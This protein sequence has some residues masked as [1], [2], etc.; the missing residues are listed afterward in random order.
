[1][2]MA[3]ETFLTLT[4]KTL[5]KLLPLLGQLNKQT[6]VLEKHMKN[7]GRSSKILKQ[8]QK[9][10]SDET[11]K[12]AQAA[13]D[14][15]SALDKLNK[16][17]QQG[18]R[19]S[20]SFE[21]FLAEEVKLKS[22]LI[23]ANDKLAIQNDRIA[24]QQG[25]MGIIA[26]NKDFAKKQLAEINRLYDAVPTNLPTRKRTSM[27]NF[28]EDTDAIK[29]NKQND[30][31]RSSLLEKKQAALNLLRKIE[32]QERRAERSLARQKT[33][34]E[35][36]VE[37]KK[38][39]E[40]AEKAAKKAAAE[41]AKAAAKAEKERLATMTKAEKE[42]E[43]L[44]KAE[45]KK[46]LKEQKEA[47]KA[48]L[49]AEKDKERARI[50]AEKEAERL[51]KQKLREE[52]KAAAEIEKAKRK[53]AAE[54]LKQQKK[55]AAELEKA[56]K[57]TL[58]KATKASKE[59]LA[60]KKKAHAALVKAQ[61]AAAAQAEKMEKKKLVAANNLKKMQE[62][63]KKKAEKLEIFKGKQ[64]E[65]K[66]ARELKTLEEQREQ[67]LRRSAARAKMLRNS[68]M[69]VYKA[70]KLTVKALWMMSKPLR[71]LGNGLVNIPK[72]MLKALGTLNSRLFS[73]FTYDFINL[74]GRGIRSIPSL[75]GKSMK[76]AGDRNSTLE[77][78]T[79]QTRDPDAAVKLID[80]ISSWAAKTPFSI[81]QSRQNFSKILQVM[82]ASKMPM[83]ENFENVFDLMNA[84]GNAAGGNQFRMNRITT[85]MAQM[86]PRNKANEM[87]FRELANS[88]V[89]L[90]PILRDMLGLAEG[91]TL[92]A[93]SV[94]SAMMIE[95]FRRYTT[96]GGVMSGA[97]DRQMRNWNGIVSNLKDILDIFM[98]QLGRP[99]V[100]TLGPWLKNL[101]NTLNK[102]SMKDAVK[103][104]GAAL[105]RSGL[106]GLRMFGLEFDG[107][108]LEEKTRAFAKSIERAALVA[109][110][111]YLWAMG[112]PS[113][114]AR[115]L[116]GG[117]KESL[118][119]FL[120]D[121]LGDKMKAVF[122]AS[123]EEGFLK[124]LMTELKTW[125]IGIVPDFAKK[126]ADE[127]MRQISQF[128][129]TKSSGPGLG[130]ELQRKNTLGNFPDK[131]K[132]T[133]TEN[134]V[135]GASIGAG[136]GSSVLAALA[137]A[138]TGNPLYA[139]LG[140]ATAFNSIASFRELSEDRLDDD[141]QKTRTYLRLAQ[142]SWVAMSPTEKKKAIGVFN[143]FENKR[144][145]D[146]SI[147][148]D[149][150]GQGTTSFFRSKRN[151]DF[152]KFM[153]FPELPKPK[154]EEEILKQIEWLELIKR[155]KKN[156]PGY[157]S[158]LKRLGIDKNSLGL[159][160]TPG[161]H[162]MGNMFGPGGGK[163]IIDQR[164]NIYTSETAVAVNQNLNNQVLSLAGVGGLF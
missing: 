44:A 77:F 20:A 99:M 42:A 13:A 152:D 149:F 26:R 135:Q 142:A 75:L 79:L 23:S 89:D 25:K 145:G 132:K 68:F 6:S 4:A 137:M 105:T 112:K 153:G 31:L 50:K 115:E 33:A 18:A 83:G 157:D 62:Q 8:A 28:I 164:N 48:R 90:K 160:G 86:L 36:L 129:I 148:D 161:R 97:M 2:K 35:K 128:R 92:K 52:K 65:L 118:F 40:E 133:F 80:D 121:K 11:V 3:K 155:L 107:S 85:T 59:A 54:L 21:R 27:G 16:A 141:A 78:L 125:A 162:G 151:K 64:K 117:T 127:L 72:R 84:F 109:E 139:A 163:I 110:D 17:K 113:A 7:L 29:T 12:N 69:A 96:G 45:E 156:G 159:M 116:G 106:V 147:T 39:E 43:K 55:A 140:L 103:E 108:T 51:A 102:D 47:E 91:E 58:R 15:S 154:D 14:A 111:F 53:E 34:Q 10:L 1:M 9:E 38:K 61:K 88:L 56:R 46:R 143:N 60:E 19:V 146:S 66:I 30:L 93:T 126:F 104:L 95:A 57:E 87:D 76:M 37:A 81:T 158:E 5:P 120:L 24:K 22:S 49:K 101:N 150:L 32:L 98:E 138:K 71:M 122:K 123:L 41:K 131:K 74:V 70:V 82:N 130:F 114:A 134:A 100:A 124:K 63:A 73:F 119:V 144:K 94:N 136:F 67:A